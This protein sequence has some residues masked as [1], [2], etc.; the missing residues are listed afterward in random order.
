MLTALLFSASSTPVPQAFP[1]LEY[2]RGDCRYATLP[3]TSPPP[4]ITPSHLEKLLLLDA[5]HVWPC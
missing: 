5:R 1:A 2:L 3:S 4:A